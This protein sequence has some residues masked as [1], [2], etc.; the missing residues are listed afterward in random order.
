MKLFWIYLRCR[1]LFLYNLYNLMRSYTLAM[2]DTLNIWS[3]KINKTQSINATTN[4]TSNNR[5]FPDTILQY[6]INYTKVFVQF[7]V[8]QQFLLCFAWYQSYTNLERGPTFRKTNSW[9]TVNPLQNGSS[10]W[11]TISTQ[12][13]FKLQI[14]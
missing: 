9:L 3:F 8:M 13:T 1:C 14:I 12:V 4:Y 10:F 2:Q 7:S 11:T 6:I 5:I